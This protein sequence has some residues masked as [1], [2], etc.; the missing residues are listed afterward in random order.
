MVPEMSNLSVV[1]EDHE[2]QTIP[3]FIAGRLTAGGID[4][5]ECETI[6]DNEFKLLMAFVVI[7]TFVFGCIVNGWFV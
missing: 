1:A 3:S 4:L 2:E 7:A 6:G 5:E